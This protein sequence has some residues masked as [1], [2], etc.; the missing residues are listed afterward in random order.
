MPRDETAGPATGRDDIDSVLHRA[1]RH[2]QGEEAAPY[3]A[4]DPYFPLDGSGDYSVHRY[5]LF[6][7]VEPRS[8]WIGGK[9]VVTLSAQRPGISEL[10]FDFG[11][12]PSRV[13]LDGVP[14]PHG[15]DVG[16]LRVLAGESLG[17]GEH[18]VEV[19]YEGKPGDVEIRGERS[20]LNT[21]NGVLAAREPHAAAFWYPVNDHPAKKSAYETE[22]TV[23][24]EFV[25]VLPGELADLSRAD[26]RAR[27]LWIADKPVASYL[28]SL[29]IE[30]LHYEVVRDGS[31][32]QIF[33]GTGRG[34]EEAAPYARAG[35]E[36]TL[37][38]VSWL[39]GLVGPYPF[40]A[41][42]GV[43]TTAAGP[44]ALETQTH[45][46]YGDQFFAGTDNPYVVAHEIA[47][48]WFGN[49]VSVDT[50]K[51]IWISEGF[52]TYASWMMSEHL[53]QGSA[54]ELFDH[55]YS[56]RS[57]NKEFWRVPPGDPSAAHL[58]STPVYER[59]AMAVHVA[60]GL[61][62]DQPFFEALRSWCSDRQYGTGTVQQ[63]IDLAAAVSGP[64]ARRILGEWLYSV[65]QPAAL[66]PP[67]DTSRI[68]PSF[69]WIRRTGDPAA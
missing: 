38:T 17:P 61:M 10:W 46:I 42:G 28:Y 34:V 57:S 37:E 31:S 3:G 1:A 66:R 44:H 64:D 50:W 6:L 48:Q 27:Y 51:D 67:A 69:G 49:S 56:L 20:W 53:D 36:R 33:T 47:H 62:G 52:A 40:N 39:A 32:P 24:D 16:K 14:V 19:V 55:F 9:A 45:P 60:R 65:N 18:E 41:L 13:T 15:T 4:G 26:G 54:D 25:A 12:R 21:G 35:L 11:L 63:F 22:I 7:T 43:V 5:R 68:P 30:P 59:G 2:A 58:L 8:G 23:P 29:L